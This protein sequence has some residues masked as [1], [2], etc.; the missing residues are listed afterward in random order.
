MH[1]FQTVKAENEF[2]GNLLEVVVRTEV[3]IF[4][5]DTKETPKEVNFINGTDQLVDADSFV[6]T[7]ASN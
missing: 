4:D 1:S 5:L 3:Y 6:N 2:Y 7:G